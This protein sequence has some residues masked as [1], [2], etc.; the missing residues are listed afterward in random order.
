MNSNS[1]SKQ[2]LNNIPYNKLIG[3]CNDFLRSDEVFIPSFLFKNSYITMTD[4]NLVEFNLDVIPESDNT[5]IQLPE[6]EGKTD[7]EKTVIK[8]KLNA[9]FEFLSAYKKRIAYKSLIEKYLTNNVSYIYVILHIITNIKEGRLY[10][11]FS[12]L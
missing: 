5:E 10:E 1:K 11:L 8:N 9:S 6:I 2:N 7:E 12:V 3:L 4:D